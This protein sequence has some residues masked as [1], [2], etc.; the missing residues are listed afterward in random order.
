VPAGRHRMTTGL[1]RIGALLAALSERWVPDAFAFAAL[2][3][4]AVFGLAL[5]LTDRG[6]LALVG[7]WYR[8]F[9]DLL[10]FAMQMS[11]VLVTGHALASAPLV[12]RGL[13]RLAALPRS[14][15]AAVALT[16]FCAGV[17]GLV[18]WGL[19]LVAGALL[20]REVALAARRRGIRVHVPLA[21]AAGYL[22]LVV[23]HSGLS[24]SVPLLVNT[25][26]HFLHASIGLVPLQETLFRPLNLAYV[27]VVLGV[28]PLLLAAM[29][30]GDAEVVEIAP[31]SEEPRMPPPVA[32]ERRGEGLARSPLLA[33]PI[34]AGGAVYLVPHLWSAGLLAVDLNLVNF[35]FL[36]MG[37]ALHGSLADYAEA[38][39]EGARAAAGVIVQFP[40]YAGIMGLMVQ[41]GLVHVVADAFV[42]LSTPLTFPFWAMVSAALVNLAVPSGG[43]QWAVQGPIVIEAARALGVDTGRA[44]MAVVF[45]DQLT[46][47]IQPFWALP[48]L[49][50]TGLRAGQVLG[51]TAVLMI[52]AFVAAA[53][54]ITWLP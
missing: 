37:L 38:A 18:H 27:A 21:A 30:P 54:A 9:W 45:G 6:A 23:W 29:H 47:M 53:A 28:A 8:G 36:M 34:V 43:G 10:A 50:I 26:G 2:L 17:L 5:G 24:G 4:V 25:E 51:Y 1:R 44:T 35:A 39:A 13:A 3:T 31:P 12:R 20:A 46:N 48:L 15:P 41:S 16:A 42:A 22:G 32:P 33:W 52:V 40:F 49:G 7:D 19:G 14:G 11:L